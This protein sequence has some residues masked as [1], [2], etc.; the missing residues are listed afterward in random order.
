MINY[1]LRITNDQLRITDYEWWITND[2]L[3]I[4]NYGLQITNY[5]LWMCFSVRNSL[6]EI[7]S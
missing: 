2:Q 7:D 5:G 3:R 4:G 6:M 1:E